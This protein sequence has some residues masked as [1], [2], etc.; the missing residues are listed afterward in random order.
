MT[1][2]AGTQSLLVQEVCNQTDAA[3]EDEQT[4]QD[5]HSHVVF[6]FFRAESTARSQ[7]VDEADG[8]TA[9]NVEDQVVLLGGG[10]SFN[11]KGVIEEF[12]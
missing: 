3:T 5:T 9:V 12:G 6:C 11:S 1:V 7:K 2:Q 4:V 10:N 8:D